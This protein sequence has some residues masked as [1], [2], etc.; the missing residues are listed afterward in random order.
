MSAL[1]CIVTAALLCSLIGCADGAAEPREDEEQTRRDAAPAEAGADSRTADASA[2]DN[3]PADDA[4]ATEK[5]DSARRPDADAPPSEERSIQQAADAQD[6]PREPGPISVSLCAEGLPRIENARDEGMWK[7]DPVF[8]DVN[9]DGHVDLA[10]I[11]RKG[12]GPRVWLGDGTGNWTDSSTGLKRTDGSSCGGGVRLHDVNNDGHLDLCVADHCS[13][14]FIYLGDGA[15]NWEMVV[16]EMFPSDIIP[17]NSYVEKFK[18]AESIA[19]GDVNKDG[20]ADLIVGASDDGGVRYYIGDGTGENWARR[21]SILPMR[22]WAPRVELRDVN[23]DGW[24]DV[25]ASYSAGPR[26]WLNIEADQGRTWQDGSAGLPSP[27]M[28]GI[29]HGLGVGD[30]NS[31]GRIDIAVANWV[32]GPE[33]YLQQANGTWEK[34][35]D[36]FPNMMG[37]AVGLDLGDLDNDGNL[38]MVVTGRLE[39]DGGYVRGVFALRGDG[40][41]DWTYLD[42]SGLPSTGLAAMSG[43]GLHD[44]NADGTLDIAACSGLVVESVTDGRRKPSLPFNLL[45]WCTELRTKSAAAGPQ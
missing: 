37:G 26:V 18:G 34:T 32:D 21:D 38:D 2:T 33:V 41:G 27:M 23:D 22:G 9:G 7:C 36:V 28:E 40:R 20:N 6:E 11:P 31:D 29:F 25:V 13:G 3:D 8:G 10:A 15:G 24:L 12:K 4:S 14:V 43:V 39:V 5:T 35:D 30:V 45:M 1:K 19:V 17:E 16:S 44:V 42:D